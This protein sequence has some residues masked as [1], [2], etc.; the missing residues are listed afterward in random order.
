MNARDTFCSHCGAR[1]AEPL[2]YPRTCANPACAVTIWANPVPVAVLLA[3][4]VKGDRTGL[5]VVRRA[6]PPRIGEL[7]LVGGFIEAHERWEAAAAREAREE[8]AVEIDARSIA[9]F[10]FTS[11]VPKT[12]RVL[13]FGEASPID[14]SALAPFAPNAEVSERG[15]VFGPRGLD[16]VFAFALHVEA[17]RRWFHA[18]GVHDDHAFTPI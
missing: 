14:A 1:F 12:D 2:V 8:V 9:P 6:N 7:A 17:A 3:P 10:W 13:L 4:I 15:L 16:D 5:L 11:T 18:R